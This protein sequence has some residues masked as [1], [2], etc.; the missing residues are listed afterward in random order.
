LKSPDKDQKDLSI[1]MGKA[2]LY[3]LAFVIPATIVQVSLYQAL[4][5]RESIGLAIR[6]VS[7]HLWWYILVFLIGIILH[8]LIH[9]LTWVHAGRKS[10]KTIS[11]G[12]N[13]KALS[14]Y[15]H[16]NEALTVRAYRLGALMPGVLLGMIPYLL[17]LFTGQ[18]GVML[19][20][21]LFTAA[22]GGDALVLWSLRKAKPEMLVLDHPSRA[23]CVIAEYSNPA[24]D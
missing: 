4:W 1:S 3:S 20:G 2:S 24:K 5:G 8:E 13:L 22:A 17:G 14:P 12:I 9:G 19:Y 11:F 7:R 21:L 18:G 6:L 15:A 16:C 23:G 10:F